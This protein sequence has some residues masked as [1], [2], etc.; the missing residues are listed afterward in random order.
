MKKAVKYLK[1]K[2]CNSSIFLKVTICLEVVMIFSIVFLSSFLT[3]KFSEMV[4]QKE[5]A[6][7]LTRVET[8]TD[9]MET[10]YNRIYSLSNYIHS[11][12][13]SS[14]MSSIV[15]NE[16]NAYDIDNVQY[17]NVFFEGVTSADSDIVDVILVATNG[18]MFSKTTNYREEIRPSYKFMEDSTIVSLMESDS[19]MVITYTNP[20]VYARIERE[21]VVSFIGKIYD[22]SIYPKKELVG[23]YVMNVLIS[24]IEKNIKVEDTSNKGELFLVN[25]TD[26]ILYST[27]ISYLD[28]KMDYDGLIE[29]DKVYYKESLIGTTSLRAV[30][31]L[32][33]EILFQEIY[34]MRDSAIFIS[35]FAL[36]VTLI[37]NRIIYRIFKKQ[38]NVL[39]ESMDQVK[40]GN[41]K[42]RLPVKSK[43]EIGI[44]SE[45]FN[46][47]CEKINNYIAQ[48]Y[49]AEIQRKNAQ[50]NALQTQINPHFLYNTLESIKA[51][52]LDENDVI[53]PE[54]IRLLG[55]LFRWSIKTNEK[56][57]I[58]EEELEY[59]KSYL[60]LQSYRFNQSL[61]IAIDIPDEYLDYAIPKLCMQP[62][63]EN[64]I[65][66][67]L[68]DYEKQGIVGIC[69]KVKPDHNLE[70]TIYDNGKGMEDDDLYKVRRKLEE[71]SEQ[72]SFESIGIQNVHQRL[73]LLF[74]EP[75]GLKIES[76]QNQGT[77]V[78]IIIPAMMKKEMEQIV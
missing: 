49:K 29:N 62:I 55:N 66:H 17:M 72:D 25:E 21:P 68:I 61:D 4:K 47:M 57:V 71:S 37:G 33:N 75:Y 8:L 45:S 19:N 58:L 48:V 53:T 27:N 22:S 5:I 77:A 40:Q 74:G 63:V 35:F 10:K 78:K 42:L 41:F 14:I 9:Y 60:Q 51:K 32:S 12:N 36:F 76:K 23:I 2:I 69:A 30:Y 70:I 65:K 24:K 13:V 31:I 59:V 39:I 43:D 67:A 26:K 11:S 46:D 3:S 28:G 54:M 44:L 38:L 1:E 15:E 64:T 16:A 7:G 50:I 73:H 18:V 6:L 52:A 56:I 20:S 34:D